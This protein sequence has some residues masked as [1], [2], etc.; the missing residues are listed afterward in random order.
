MEV[1]DHDKD[2][3]K[4]Q[5]NVC[6]K[7]FSSQQTLTLHNDS[8]HN[9]KKIQCDMCEKIF[10]KESD[11]KNHLASFHNEQDHKRVED[12][13]NAC[14]YCGK[15]LT[16]KYKLKIHIDTVHKNIKKSECDQCR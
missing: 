4:F 3:F 7:A 2:K 5:C 6:K 1:K 15:K 12:F 14:N 8:L 13:H 16:T 11:M 9:D 10:A